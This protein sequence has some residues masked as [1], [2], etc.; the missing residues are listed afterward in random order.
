MFYSDNPLITTSSNKPF[1]QAKQLAG[2]RAG[3][4]V[5][6]LPDDTKG[7]RHQRFII[8]LA[9]GQ[10]LLVAHN[11]DL[12]PPHRFP[13][14]GRYDRIL[15]RVRVERK[16]RGGSLNPPRPGRQACGRVDLLQGAEV[17]LMPICHQSANQLLT[18]ESNCLPD[19]RIFCSID[20]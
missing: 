6:I 17:S 4:V 16:G 1:N 10:T 9:A 5:A 13:G 7:R 12:A 2:S 11:I 15:W 20:I 3:G 14:Q 18:L 8:R 19:L